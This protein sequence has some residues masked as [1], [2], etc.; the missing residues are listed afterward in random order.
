[1]P[2]GNLSHRNDNLKIPAGLL[3][4]WNHNLKLSPDNLSHW[5]DNLKKREGILADRNHDLKLL[6]D[7]LKI[8]PGNL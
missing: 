2:P 6:P 5:N 1:M 3:A 4:D 7:D 8:V